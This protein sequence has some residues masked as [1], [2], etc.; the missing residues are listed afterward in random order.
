M[1]R[2]S[3]R[4]LPPYLA[5]ILIA[6]AFFM[7]GGLTEQTVVRMLRPTELELDWVS[8]VVLSVALGVAVY[9]WLHLRA[10]RRTLSERERAQLVTEAQLSMAEA[11]QRRLL[12][13]LPSGPDGFDWAAV[14]KPAT[15]IGGDFYDFFDD[16]SGTRLMLIADVSGKGI[17]AAMALTLLRWTFHHLAR[18]TRQPSELATSMSALFHAEWQGTPYITAAIAAVDTVGLTLT[19]TNAGHPPGLLIRD[20][21]PRSLEE[22]G[23]PLGLLADATYAEQR[24]ELRPGDVFLFVSDGIS[25]AFDDGDRSW[26]T[27]ALEAV[28]GVRQRSADEIC[29][30]LLDRAQKAHGPVGVDHWTDDRTVVVLT[31]R[32]EFPAAEA[33]R[34]DVER[35]SAV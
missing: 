9:L 28:K 16:G 35:S 24:L 20:G 33:R 7:I 23:P 25:E 17:S 13:P 11:M 19:C 21:A 34:R 32:K 29:H 8:D 6:L 3:I 26:R 27:A 31:V 12:P 10:T 5:A 4:T 1:P 30:G 2:L 18:T 14:L 15:R 22:G